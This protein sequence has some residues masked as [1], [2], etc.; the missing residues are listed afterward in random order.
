MTVIL[1]A[2]ISNA[3]IAVPLSNSTGKIVPLSEICAGEID[4]IFNTLSFPCFSKVRGGITHSPFHVND[5]AC[6]LSISVYL[7]LLPELGGGGNLQLQVSA[8][9]NREEGDNI[10]IGD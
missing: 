2:K 3:I 1:S 5:C 4:R 10:D 6:I 8:T 7:C 9:I